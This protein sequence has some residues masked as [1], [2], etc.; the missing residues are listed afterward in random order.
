[1]AE[2]RARRSLVARKECDMTAKARALI[3]VSLGVLALT[4]VGCSR[5]EAAQAP[6]PT[7]P[8]TAPPVPPPAAKVAAPGAYEVRYYVL[9]NSCPYCR[10]LRRVIEGG[11]PGGE[12]QAPLAKVYEG[13]VKFDFRPA[14]LEGG[15]TNPE[16][17]PFHFGESAHGFAGVAPDGTVKFALPGHHQTRNDLVAAIDGMLK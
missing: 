11:T 4:A 13:R 12:P 5:E 9:D 10:D 17:A 14:F 7:A 6:P 2:G 15:R 8:P 16:M 3:L 1:M